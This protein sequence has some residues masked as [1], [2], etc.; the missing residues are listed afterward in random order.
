MS[1]VDFVTSDYKKLLELNDKWHQ[2]VKDTAGD[3][4]V[5]HAKRARENGCKCGIKM[6]VVELGNG[7]VKHTL[8]NYVETAKAKM[9]VMGSR[10]AGAFGRAFVGSVSDFCVHNSPVSVVVVK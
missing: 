5:K 10:G 1:A 6:K 2:K 7:S 3:M 8:L 4:L 9:V